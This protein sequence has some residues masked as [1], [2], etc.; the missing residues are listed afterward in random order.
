MIEGDKLLNTFVEDPPPRSQKF[1]MSDVLS[2]KKIVKTLYI[3]LLQRIYKVVTIG[4]ENHNNQKLPAGSET[5]FN[6]TFI[7]LL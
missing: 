5:D 3:S 4:E 7:L 1:D 6:P 2:K